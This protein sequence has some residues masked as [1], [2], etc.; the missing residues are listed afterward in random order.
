MGKDVGT[1]DPKE[2]ILTCGQHSVSG[3]AEDSFISLAKQGEG[4]KTRVGCDGEMARSLDPNQQYKITFKLLQTSDSNGIFQTQYDYDYNTGEGMF[5]VTLKDL[6]GTV[7]FNA[8]QAWVVKPADR[9]F[10]KEA[11]EWEWE[12]DTGPG[13]LRQ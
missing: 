4:V 5:A 2:V 3:Y 1:Y 8:D 6:S 10:G 7:V 9:E 13:K 11:G 12:I